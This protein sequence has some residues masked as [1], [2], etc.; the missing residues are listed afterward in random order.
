MKEEGEEEVTEEATTATAKDGD[1]TTMTTAN[2]EQAKVGEDE[3]KEAKV[4]EGEGGE[5]E[6]VKGR[7]NIEINNIGVGH[8]FANFLGFRSTLFTF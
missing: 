6:V 8:S 1:T 5:E 7:E 4:K 3:A 2:T